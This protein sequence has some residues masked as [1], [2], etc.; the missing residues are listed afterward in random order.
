M[1]YHSGRHFLQLPGPTNTPDRVLRAMSKPT[2]DHRGPAFKE[3]TARLLAGMRWLFRTE[4]TVLIHPASG[5]GAW[6]AA[7]VNTLSPGDQVLAFDQG[8]FAET[9]AKVAGRFGL[10]VR[11]QP[12]IHAEA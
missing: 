10:D 2:I 5:S 6:E 8:F 4:H 9:W 11:L 7:M 3:L 12:W 1:T